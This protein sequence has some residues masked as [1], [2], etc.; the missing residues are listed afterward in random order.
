MVDDSLVDVKRNLE[1]GGYSNLL[2]KMA[3]QYLCLLDIIYWALILVLNSY[4]QGHHFN[5]MVRRK[6]HV[7]LVEE[8]KESVAQ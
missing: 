5:L 6:A 4:R 3:S 2:L 1:D 7:L 8:E